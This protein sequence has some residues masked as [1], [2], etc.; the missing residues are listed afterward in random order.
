[1]VKSIHTAGCIKQSSELLTRANNDL[2][3]RDCRKTTHDFLRRKKNPKV[4]STQC[5]TVKQV[6]YK[7]VQESVAKPPL[8][9]LLRFQVAALQP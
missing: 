7:A 3:G 5:H 4:P 8:Q 2:V 9:L 6:Q 1:M